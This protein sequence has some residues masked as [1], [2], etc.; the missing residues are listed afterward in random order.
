MARVLVVEDDKDCQSMLCKVI[1]RSGADAVGFEFLS[2]DFKERLV[3]ELEKN[4]YTLL[5]CDGLEGLWEDVH[6]LTMTRVR[7]F[8][9]YSGNK[10]QVNRAREQGIEAYVKDVSPSAFVA[11]VLARCQELET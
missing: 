2:G 5:V 4:N 7:G 3:A 1:S 6:K 8:L 11:Y 10:D 9:L